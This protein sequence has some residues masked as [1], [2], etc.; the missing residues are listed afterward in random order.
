M[1]CDVSDDSLKKRL[2]VAPPLQPKLDRREVAVSV[3]KLP[4]S[5][6]ILNNN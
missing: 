1:V 5:E 6:A 4:S 3:K 2:I